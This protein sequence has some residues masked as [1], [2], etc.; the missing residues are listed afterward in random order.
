MVVTEITGFKFNLWQ[1]MKSFNWSEEEGIYQCTW[2]QGKQDSPQSI[3]IP[4]FRQLFKKSI[5][6]ITLWH[7]QVYSI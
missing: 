7:W 4:E 1:H 6:K 3:V 2:Y 5:L